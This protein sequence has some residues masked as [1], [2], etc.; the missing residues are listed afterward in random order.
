MGDFKVGD[1]VKISNPLNIC[2]KYKDTIHTV[3]N[4]DD[5]YVYLDIDDDNK[6]FRAYLSYELEHVDGFE[7]NSPDL[8]D[9][10][11]KWFQ[12]QST[13]SFI[14]EDCLDAF[15]YAIG[16]FKTIDKY[17]KNEE[18]KDM[19]K[20]LKLWHDR[21]VEKIELKYNDLVNEYIE[22][23]SEIVN[24]YKELIEKFEEDLETLYDEE[25]ENK[26]SESSILKEN[27]T[28]NVYKY[29]VNEDKLRNEAHD[30][31]RVDRFKE[32]EEQ[33]NKR[34]EV[35]AL[36]SMSEDLEY[37]QSVL[38]EYGIIDKKTKRMI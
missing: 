28:C 36:L 25:N 35:D 32:L 8:G 18:E 1:L 30:L 20:V 5:E 14:D 13:V 23:H 16:D 37:Q 17:I 2:N 19:N 34:N 7:E 11:E 26:E 4:I 38:I 27:N 22:K 33:D 21:N 9:D 10:V 15:R 6:Y 29:V 3:V 12:R 31:Y 24:K